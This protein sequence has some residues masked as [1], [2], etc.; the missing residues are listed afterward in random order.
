[1]NS[2]SALARALRGPLMLTTFGTLLSIDYGGGA[3]IQTT[4]PVLIIVYGV[5]RLAEAMLPKNAGPG[6]PGLGQ[7]GNPAGGL[8]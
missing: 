2:V 3:G 5:L 6:D 4:W 7:S 1:V 8:S